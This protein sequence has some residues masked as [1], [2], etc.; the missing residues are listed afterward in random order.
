MYDVT[1]YMY[2]LF[3]VQ[4]THSRSTQSRL[5]DIALDLVQEIFDID[6]LGF[7]DVEGMEGAY[8][9]IKFEVTSNR[10]ALDGPFSIVPK[11][12]LAD[13]MSFLN[14]HPCLCLRPAN[15]PIVQCHSCHDGSIFRDTLGNNNVCLR[16]ARAIYR[17][18]RFFETHV[19]EH[20]SE[21][22]R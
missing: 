4:L 16:F 3:I 9:R 1:R 2:I 5:A 14:L 22:T 11:P 17:I 8:V 18:R 20:F 12:N 19:D 10:P 6:S 21:F 7:V 13:Q 15:D